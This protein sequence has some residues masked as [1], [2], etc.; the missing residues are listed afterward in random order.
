MTKASISPISSRVDRS[1]RF[2]P[3]FFYQGGETWGGGTAGAALG[4]WDFDGLAGSER[5]P[6]VGLGFGSKHRGFSQHSR[7]LLGPVDRPGRM[8]G[9]QTDA[10]MGRSQNDSRKQIRANLAKVVAHRQP[11]K[12]F[13]RRT[14]SGWPGGMPSGCD[15]NCS[16]HS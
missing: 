1:P 5:G 13:S 14:G 16:S 10:V 4:C 11:W 3:R 8:D 2:F 15:G 6:T 7:A 9:R 12:V